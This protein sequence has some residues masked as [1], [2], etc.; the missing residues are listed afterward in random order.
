LSS[1]DSKRTVAG[2]GCA[3]PGNVRTV[4]R[5]RYLVLNEDYSGDVDFAAEAIRLTSELH[6]RM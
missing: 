6:A 5:E 1:E 3:A 2:V 4:A